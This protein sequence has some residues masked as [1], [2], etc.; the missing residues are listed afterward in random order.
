MLRSCIG[1][2]NIILEHAEHLRKSLV[3]EV[4][5]ARMHLVEQEVVAVVILVSELSLE[6]LKIDG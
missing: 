2:I 5:V 1:R 6:L 3:P 4:D